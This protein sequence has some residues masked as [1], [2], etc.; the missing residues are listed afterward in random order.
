MFKIKSDA[1]NAREIHLKVLTQN[2]PLS[3]SHSKTK[4]PGFP[5]FPAMSLSSARTIRLTLAVLA[6]LKHKSGWRAGGLGGSGGEG[7]NG[8]RDRERE[9]ERERERTDTSGQIFN[10]F[11]SL[12]VPASP[13]VSSVPADMINVYELAKLWFVSKAEGFP[14][15]RG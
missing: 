8:R 1:G 12:P 10:W 11:L 14:S 9:R 6:S 13:A 7:R 4:N 3:L 5:V 15:Q 2:L